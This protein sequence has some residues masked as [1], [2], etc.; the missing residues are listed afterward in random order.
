M[1]LAG[2]NIF[3]S[4]TISKIADYLGIGVALAFLIHPLYQRLSRKKTPIENEVD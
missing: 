2:A 4:E 3:T 1:G